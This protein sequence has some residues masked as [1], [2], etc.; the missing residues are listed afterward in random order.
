MK[1]RGATVKPSEPGAFVE[2]IL[3]KT[4][5][6]SC[7]EGIAHRESLASVEIQLSKRDNKSSSKIGAK[8]E[9]NSLK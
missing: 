1:S 4:E 9:N 2:P 3:V 5:N 8:E 6:I 7:S